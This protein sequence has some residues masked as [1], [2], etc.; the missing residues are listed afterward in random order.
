LITSLITTHIFLDYLSFYNYR[1]NGIGIA[2]FG[3][4]P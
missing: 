3:S 4:L 2:Y 1:K